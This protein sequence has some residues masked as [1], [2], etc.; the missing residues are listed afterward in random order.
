MFEAY[1]SLYSLFI[2]LY[3]IFINKSNLDDQIWKTK[4]SLSGKDYDQLILSPI[5]SFLL[6]LCYTFYLVYTPIFLYSILFFLWP[7]LLVFSSSSQDP[8]R[9]PS[10]LLTPLSRAQSLQSFGR[11]VSRCWVPQSHGDL[12]SFWQ[13]SRRIKSNVTLI[14]LLTLKNLSNIAQPKDHRSTQYLYDA[15]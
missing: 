10:S 1:W 7:P 13:V 15:W 11:A 14:S 2:V 9:S 5:S 8:K 6:F 3:V 4:S 12:Q